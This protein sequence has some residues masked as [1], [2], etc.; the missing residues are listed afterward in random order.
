MSVVHYKFMK[1]INDNL[2]NYHSTLNRPIPH[3]VYSV[4]VSK[5]QGKG[6][7]MSKRIVPFNHSK[8]VANFKFPGT[9]IHVH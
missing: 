1:K 2:L 7:A 9:L 3:R 5:W 4:S 8:F 6:I